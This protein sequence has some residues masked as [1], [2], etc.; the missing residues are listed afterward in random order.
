VSRAGAN[1][2]RPTGFITH[3]LHSTGTLPMKTAVWIATL[4]ILPLA[5]AGCR[6]AG[7][8]APPSRPTVA[9]PS[10]DAAADA[11]GG[12]AGP[13]AWATSKGE[14]RESE[15]PR[16]EA[17]KYEP[18]TSEGRVLGAVGKAVVGSLRGEAEP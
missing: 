7:R 15:A 5:L 10:G 16:R 6:P 4:A 2:N 12:P 14:A 1:R 8:E 13:G 17:W 3:L 18:K 9:A 11:T